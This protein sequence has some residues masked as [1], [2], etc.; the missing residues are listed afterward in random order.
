MEKELELQEL[1][2]VEGRAIRT[3]FTRFENVYGHGWRASE[4]AF[5]Q[6]VGIDHIHRLWYHM[7][8][9]NARKIEMMCGPHGRTMCKAII[10]KWH[11]EMI[12]DSTK[13]GSVGCYHGP[14]N[15]DS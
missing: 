9:S 6:I 4:H 13:Y 1:I 3:A 8:E 12:Y 11:A 15:D 10:A 14:D 7:T 2:R 5:K